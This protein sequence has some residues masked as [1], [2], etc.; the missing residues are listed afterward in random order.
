MLPRPG[1]PARIEL[2]KW[3]DRPHWELDATYLGSDEHGDWLGVPAGTAHSR[4]GA[5]FTSEVDS[6]TLAPRDRPWCA[7][8]HAPGI[9]CTV[10]VDMTTPPHWDGAVV[11]AVDLDLDVIRGSDGRVRVDDEDE[12][13]EHQV[14]LGYPAEIVRVAEASRDAVLNA[15]RRAQPPFDLDTCRPWLAQVADLTPP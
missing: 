5:S 9:W 1:D 10:Y 11:R 2:S 15:V 8:F 12:F 6:V 7:T 3:G 4:P 14:T 13:A